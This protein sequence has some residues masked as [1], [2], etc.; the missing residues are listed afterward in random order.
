MAEESDKAQIGLTPAGNQALQAL[1]T[2]DL[3]EA[4]G[5]AY[6]FAI[7]YSLA[8]EFEPTLAAD[9]GYQTKFNAQGGL[10]REGIVRDL[11]AALRPDDSARPYATAERLA[12]IGLIDLARRI[13]G[14]ESLAE[15]LAQVS[16][17]THEAPGPTANR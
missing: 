8:C 13:E 1:M 4:E 7:A 17:Q 16:S 15:I 3:F 14:H 12:E 2:A 10:D 9:G 11:I 6:K 5:D